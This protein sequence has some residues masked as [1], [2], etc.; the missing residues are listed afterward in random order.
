MLAEWI[1]D[2]FPE[3]RV[4][5][6][7]FGGAASV[8]VRKNRSYA[9]VYN[10]LDKQA[11]NLFRVLQ[12]PPKAKRLIELL[13][14]TLYAREEFELA[15]E[16]IKGDVENARRLVVRSFMG[17]GSDACGKATASSRGFRPS[18]GFR[19]VSNASGTSPARD[20]ANYPTALG[21]LVERFRGVVIE[22]RD[23]LECMSQHD[24]PET[25]HYV[26]PPYI[27]STRTTQRG[28]YNHEMTDAD[29]RKLVQFL[30][31]LKG[32]VIVSGYDH[33]IYHKL[34]WETIK[35]KA[36]ADGAAE[37]VECLWLNQAAARMCQPK[38]L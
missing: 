11:V 9:E 5:V 29:H 25:L 2:H 31:K 28:K 4:Y 18:T 37:R 34:G 38:L 10:D 19:A 22:C 3:H 26:D 1:I 14:L 20:W 36:F 35:R 21:I 23:A 13:N 12:D 6:E 27:H 30:G 7:P 33:E 15:F 8:L 32:A 16:P 24:S 17:F